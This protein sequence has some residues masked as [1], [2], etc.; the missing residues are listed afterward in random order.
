[1]LLKTIGR[2]WYGD[3]GQSNPLPPHK[4]FFMGLASSWERLKGM[5]GV[6]RINGDYFFRIVNGSQTWGKKDSNKKKMEMVLENPAA[7]YVFLLLP[8]IFSMGRFYMTTKADEPKE[9]LKH[10][11]LDLLNKPNPMQTTQQFLWDY[12]FWRKTGTANLYIDSKVPTE[13]NRMYFLN[14]DHIDWPKGAKDKKDFIFLSDNEVNELKRTL[15]T[16]DSNG[17]KFKF[18]YD[19]LKQYF[20]ISNGLGNW[21]RSP[22]RIEAIYKIVENSDS[23]LRAKNINIDFLGKFIVSGKVDVSNTSQ[24]MMGD[25]DK[26]SVRSAMHSGERIFPTKTPVNINRFIDNAAVLKELD[27]SFM[28]DAFL[29][30]KMLNI[31]RDVLE[32]LASS[33]YENQEKAR[34]SLVSYCIQPDADDFCSGLLEHFGLADGY[35]LQLQFDHLPFVQAFEKDKAETW[36]TKADAFSKFVNAGARPEETAAMMEI[37]D[38]FTEFNEHSPS[39]TNS[40]NVEDGK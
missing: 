25:D 35:T 17:Q 39:S 20:D 7:M 32:M 16:Y 13:K 1:M 21:F 10:P 19:Q 2:H 34:A 8:E 38:W 3:L 14:G 12:M 11:L 22:S 40:N 18:R 6:E 31:P 5:L 27:A 29:I 15:L 26:L 24:M 36:R 37:G 30:G 9:V 4:G 33:T 23:A 28:N